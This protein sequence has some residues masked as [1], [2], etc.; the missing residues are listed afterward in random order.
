MV[1]KIRRLSFDEA[2]KTLTDRQEAMLY[3]LLACHRMSGHCAASCPLMRV[4]KGGG[5]G[6]GEG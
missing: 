4:V 1:K 3:C 2:V 5:L 6:H